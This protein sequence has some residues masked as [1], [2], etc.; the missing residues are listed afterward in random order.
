MSAGNENKS[1]LVEYSFLALLCTVQFNRA[2]IH[3]QSFCFR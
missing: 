3:L 1:F 2:E